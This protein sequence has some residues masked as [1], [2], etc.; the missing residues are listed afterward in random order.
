MA[1]QVQYTATL[2]VLNGRICLTSTPESAL[3]WK[4]LYA[5]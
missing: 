5:T 2:V 4:P 3:R 1:Q